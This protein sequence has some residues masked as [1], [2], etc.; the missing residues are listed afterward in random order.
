MTQ[1]QAQASGAQ[2]YIDS[3]T[4]GGDGAPGNPLRVL[5]GA[6]GEA[7]FVW[8]VAKTWAAIY[9]EMLAVPGPKICLVEFD[10]AAGGR[11]VTNT[12]VPQDLNNVFFWGMAGAMTGTSMFITVNAGF[13][14]AGTVQFGRT[15]AFFRSKDIS[16]TFNA[17]NIFDP[18]GSGYVEFDIDGGALIQGTS[19]PIVTGRVILN[20]RNRAAIQ[21]TGA[22]GMFA[23][24]DN[25]SSV[26]LLGGSNLSAA[27][28]FK[29]TGANIV[30][31]W[32]DASSHWPA[33]AFSSVTRSGPRFNI[34]ANAAGALFDISVDGTGNVIATARS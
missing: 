32:A 9:A 17:G 31:T 18:V 4:I 2:F 3:K 26:V 21:A 16:W 20:G 24:D 28:V 13:T 15:S 33:S 34:A 8:T 19:T 12:G 10:G 23:C 22:N 7:V 1:T 5:P 14:L 11:T 27:P 29:G 25:G 30:S 6:G